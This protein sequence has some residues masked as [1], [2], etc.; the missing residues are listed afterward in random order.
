MTK[1]TG[2][3]SFVKHSPAEKE[4]ETQ[5]KEE[6]PQQQQQH[7]REKVGLEKVGVSSANVLVV[8]L[9]CGAVETCLSW[10]P[11][12]LRAVVDAV[13]AAVNRV[14]DHHGVEPT[15]LA[16]QLATEEC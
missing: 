11:A 5:Q 3:V 12:F 15:T 4:E 7:Q 13:K 14:L 2:A 6:E 9:I 10:D 16:E 1:R 8:V